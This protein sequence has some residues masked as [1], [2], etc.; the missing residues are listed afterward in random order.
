MSKK[1]NTITNA[2]ATFCA[3]VAMIL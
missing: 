1:K 2:K 3:F